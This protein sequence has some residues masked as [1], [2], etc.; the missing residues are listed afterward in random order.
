MPVDRFGTLGEREVQLACRGNEYRRD[1][2]RGA[3][4]RNLMAH[5]TATT[6]LGITDRIALVV[7]TGFG[8]GYSPVAP[9]TCG[10]FLGI[11]LILLLSRLKL[12]GGSRLL[13]FL[14]LVSVISAAGIWAA[15]RAE[16]LFRRKDPPQV[17]IV[18][19]VGQLLTLGLIFKHPRFL[20]L[21]IGFFFFRLFDIVKPFPIR[22]VERVPLGFGIVL[23]DLVAGFY[24]SLVVFVLHLWWPSLT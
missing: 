11:L 12:S 20:F 1:Q 15:S 7:A 10:S 24:A 6:P 5:P 9:G 18:E 23:D 14:I 21:M 3:E 16:L 8:S 4:R 19:I 2:Q 17:V 22:D 13:L